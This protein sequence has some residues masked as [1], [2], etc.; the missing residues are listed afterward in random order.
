MGAIKRSLTKQTARQDAEQQTRGLS[1]AAL[2]EVR[3]TMEQVLS[4][5]DEEGQKQV[6]L[7]AM[8]SVFL[9]ERH[10]PGTDVDGVW[11]MGKVQADGTRALGIAHLTIEGLSDLGVMGVGMEQAVLEAL[12]EYQGTAF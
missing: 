2:E 5:W 12:R 6:V 7:G 8:A 3:S 1:K 11:L 10:Q 4:Q 9:S